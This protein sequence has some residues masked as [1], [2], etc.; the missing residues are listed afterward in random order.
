M[1]HMLLQPC[2]ETLVARE[3]NADH[4]TGFGDI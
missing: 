2:L 4:R 1:Q 3:T